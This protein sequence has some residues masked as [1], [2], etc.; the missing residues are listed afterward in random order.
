MRRRQYL[1]LLG[2]GGAGCLAAVGWAIQDDGDERAAE[3]VADGRDGSGSSATSSSGPGDGGALSS[4]AGDGGPAGGGQPTTADLSLPVDEADLDRAAPRD[5]IPAIVDPVFG[6]SWAE[7]DY[8]VATDAYRSPSLAPTDEVIGVARGGTARAYPL[9]LL[10][11]H[12]VV[13]DDIGGPLLVTYCPI[14]KS[15]LVA[16]RRVDGEARTFG[17]SGYLF[18]ANLVLYDQ[19]GGNLW[20]QLLATAIRGPATG[21]ELGLITSRTTTWEAWQ[22]EYP[23]T[24][25]LLPPP[26]SNTVVGEVALNYALDPYADHETVAERYP[27]Y[28]PLGDLEWSD[29]RL[30]RRTPVLGVVHDGEA[31]AY[32]RREIEWN[33]PIND[34]VGSRPVVVATAAD[35]TLVAY[36]RRAGGGRLR[37]SDGGGRTLLAGGSRWRRLTGRALDGPHEGAQLASATDVSELYWAAWFK[38][39]PETT[40]YGEE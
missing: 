23:G 34:T 8:E 22:A 18:R 4:P 28:G 1:A 16:D 37:F 11:R 9:K 30:Q 5:G 6:S 20:S 12:E 29:T 25:V 33:G 7:T 17:V 19:G 40:V 10:T 36:D 13:N 27:E 24:E 21:T 39:H 2:A 32:P 3:P 26:A 31:V 14:C 35:G 15:G 38:F